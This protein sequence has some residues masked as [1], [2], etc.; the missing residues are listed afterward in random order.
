MSHLESLYIVIR[1]KLKCISNVYITKKKNDF[2]RVKELSKVL[3]V[4]IKLHQ[5]EKLVDHNYNYVTI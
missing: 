1:M 2:K 3:Q 4:E 5:E